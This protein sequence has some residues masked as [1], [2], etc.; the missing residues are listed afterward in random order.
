MAKIEQ[1]AINEIAR[2]NEEFK[3]VRKEVVKLK[4]TYTRILTIAGLSGGVTGIITSIIIYL[5]TQ[6]QGG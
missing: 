4:I 1:T 2:V 6:K 3:S 5:L